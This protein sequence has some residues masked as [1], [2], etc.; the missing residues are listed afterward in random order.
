MSELKYKSYPADGW[1][2]ESAET[3]PPGCGL[4]CLG[5]SSSLTIA[6]GDNV[7]LALAGLV[8]TILAQTKSYP[9]SNQRGV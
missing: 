1:H 9:F 8:K 4:M 2:L 7:I 3:R 5:C 6:S